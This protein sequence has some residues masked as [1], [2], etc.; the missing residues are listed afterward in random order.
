MAGDDAFFLPSFPAATQTLY[1]KRNTKVNAA[2]CPTHG[3]ASL[4]G[5]TSSHHPP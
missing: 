2:Y 4:K 1:V 3:I 5:R